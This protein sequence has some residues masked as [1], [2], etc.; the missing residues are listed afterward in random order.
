MD[1]DDEFD[2]LQYREALLQSKLRHSAKETVHDL[3]Y[4][5]HDDFRLTSNKNDPGYRAWLRSKLK[6]INNEELMNPDFN[7]DHFVD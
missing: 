7:A 1:H 5:L 6:K 2:E 4:K 3:S